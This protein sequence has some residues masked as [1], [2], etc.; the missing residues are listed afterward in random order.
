MISPK[1]PLRLTD[2]SQKYSS[3]EGPYLSCCGALSVLLLDQENAGFRLNYDKSTGI[4]LAWICGR[5]WHEGEQASVI[6]MV[7]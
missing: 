3:C 6:P 4:T 7:C 5:T 1:C 2:P